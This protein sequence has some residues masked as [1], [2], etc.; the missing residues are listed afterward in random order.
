MGNCFARVTLTSRYPQMTENIIDKLNLTELNKMI[1]VNRYVRLIQ[2]LDTLTYNTTFMFNFL[3]ILITIG[4][5]MV[6]ALLSIEKK[7]FF[8]NYNVNIT[9]TSTMNGDSEKQT[10]IQAHYI[11]WLTFSLSIVVTMSNGIIKLFSIDK[12]YII[13]HLRYNDLNRQ[14][15][16][17]FSLSGPY[18]KYNTH[19]E[20]I[21]TFLFNV[22]K[23]RTTQ[24]LEEFTP[25][26]SAQKEQL[27]YD[28]HSVDVINND[29]IL[30]NVRE[31]VRENMRET[32][33][34]MPTLPSSDIMSNVNAKE[35]NIIIR[36]L[37]AD[38]G[39]GQ[40]TTSII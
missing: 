24:I 31:N 21:R 14:G 1:I 11:F 19:N 9:D 7:A 13:R 28:V 35:E 2:K 17:F 10:D 36:Y 15:W 25:E 39:P 33:I 27:T 5:I 34:K 26:T 30:Q 16:L 4:S 20:A 37:N 38:G 32:K 3:S 8:L 12:T 23:L 29:T 40:V 18:T 22:E 6:P